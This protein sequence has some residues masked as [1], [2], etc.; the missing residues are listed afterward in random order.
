MCPPHSLKLRTFKYALLFSP[1]QNC[2]APIMLHLAVSAKS[3]TQSSIINHGKS[4]L[5]LRECIL[6]KPCEYFN[7]HF[8][9]F[10]HQIYQG[11]PYKEITIKLFNP[12]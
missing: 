9:D 5:I 10:K 6:E 11:A 2:E 1:P 12:P 8:Q 7:A 4:S 3:S